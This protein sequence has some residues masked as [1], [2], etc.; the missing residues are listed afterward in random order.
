M[1]CFYDRK[2]S[3]SGT[4]LVTCQPDNI[5]WP[6]TKRKTILTKLQRSLII[7]RRL[8]SS[9]SPITIM[10]TCTCPYAVS[11][12]KLI[13]LSKKDCDLKTFGQILYMHMCHISAVSLNLLIKVLKSDL[14]NWIFQQNIISLSSTINT[15]STNINFHSFIN[16]L[17][18]NT[19][20]YFPSNVMDVFKQSP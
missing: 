19:C 9:S 7:R 1:H 4:K 5:I 11:N 3:G 20:K 2:F 6:G 8:R 13:V 16:F 18:K 10:Y 15:F 14:Q 17:N 12:I